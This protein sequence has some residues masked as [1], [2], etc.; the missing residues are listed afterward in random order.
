MPACLWNRACNQFAVKSWRRRVAGRSWLAGFRQA[1]VVPPSACMPA[2]AQPLC[3]PSLCCFRG[4]LPHAVPLH[5]CASLARRS[6]PPTP[7]PAPSS[8]L[9]IDT[10]RRGGRGTWVCCLVAVQLPVGGERPPKHL[11][12][13]VACAPPSCS[14][15]HCNAAPSTSQPGRRRLRGET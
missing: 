6:R 8:T 13:C 7:S 5:A 10:S 3:H 11:L 2:L 4:C 1:P 14:P 9:P 15:H 12:P